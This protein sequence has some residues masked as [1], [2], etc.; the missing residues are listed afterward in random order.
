M[1]KPAA[2]YDDLIARFRWVVPERYNIA[3]SCCDNWAMADPERVAVIS[4]DAGG[5][6]F[7]L[8]YREL[9]EKANRLANAL[10][11]R[12][13][14]PGDRVAI[15]LPQGRSLPIAHMAVYKLGAVAV[16]LANLFG[17]DAIGYRLTDSGA[18]ALITNAAGLE[19]GRRP[20]SL[21][22]AGRVASGASREGVA[23]VHPERAARPP[24]DPALRFGPPS[25][26]GGGMKH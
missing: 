20:S 9:Q 5:D 3:T 17:I 19:K 18:A 23:P 11:A 7:T 21:P 26:Q 2:T 16:P 13:V 15:M 1:L 25:P 24:P 8:S 14:Q 4:V 12:G 10:A 6:V 22:L